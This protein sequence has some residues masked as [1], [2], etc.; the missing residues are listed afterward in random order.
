MMYLIVLSLYYFFSTWRRAII[1]SFDNSNL[2]YIQ[3]I[4][5]RLCYV[6]NLAKILF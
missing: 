2:K 6:F 5:F 3:V 4:I 1:A